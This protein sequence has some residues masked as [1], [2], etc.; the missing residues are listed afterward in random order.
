MS[1]RCS[2]GDSRCPGPCEHGGCVCEGPHDSFNPDYQQLH[3]FHPPYEAC[4]ARKEVLGCNRCLKEGPTHEGKHTIAW[5][6]LQRLSEDYFLVRK[7]CVIVEW[8]DVTL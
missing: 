2:C 5:D 6:G 3:A 4:L 1:D 7:W 8:E